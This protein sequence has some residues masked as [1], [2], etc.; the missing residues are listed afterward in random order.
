M[1][2]FWLVFI[3]LFAVGALVLAGCQTTRSGYA[4]ADYHTLRSSGAFELRD[5]AALTVVETPMVGP[6]NSDNGSFMRLFR[7]ISGNN[8]PRQKIAMTTPVFM[9]GSGTNTTMAFVMPST[10][11]GGGVPQPVD[12]QVRVREVAAGRFAVLRFRGW[13]SQGNAAQALSLLRS[14]MKAEGLPELAPPMYGY[15]DP[16]WTLPFF[17]RN[18]VM[19][20]TGNGA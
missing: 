2:K 3:G 13:R 17:R 1:K 16:P 12:P 7:F 5:Y 6:G 11:K 19:I 9:A 18:E 15:F 20:R 10:L 14:W 4:T 8:Q